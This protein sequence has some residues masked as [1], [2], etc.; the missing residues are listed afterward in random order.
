MGKVDEQQH[1]QEGGREDTP[2]DP[3]PFDYFTFVAERLAT[4]NCKNS[5]LIQLLT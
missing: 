5:Y 2:A 4:P 3:R 1:E